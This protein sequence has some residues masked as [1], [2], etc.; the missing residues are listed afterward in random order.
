M[1]QLDLTSLPPP[2]AE[3]MFPDAGPDPVADEQRESLPV[4]AGGLIRTLSYLT[5]LACVVAVAGPL[6]RLLYSPVLTGIAIA[7]VVAVLTLLRAR[8]GRTPGGL[9]SGTVAVAN[10]SDHAPGLKRQLVRTTL[11]VLLHVTVVGPLVVSFFSRDGRD[12]VDRV[13]GTAVLDLRAEQSQPDSGNGDEKAEEPFPRKQENPGFPVPGAPT[14]PPPLAPTAPP[15]APTAPPLAPVSPPPLAP[16]SPPPLAPVPPPPI[17]NREKLETPQRPEKSLAPAASPLTPRRAASREPALAAPSGNTESNS[18]TP[19][20]AAP[21]PP[22]PPKPSPPSAGPS[23][24]P[25]AVQVWLVVDSGQR[26]RVDSVLVVGREPTGA[27]GERHVVIPDPTHSISRTHLRL[28]PAS[29]GVWVEDAASTNGTVVRNAAG[30]IAHLARGR[31]TLLP[32]GT[33]IIMGGRT[34]MIVGDSPQ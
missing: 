28:G 34:M 16:A 31:R 15:L 22:T 21:L 3:T 7:E 8:T 1:T 33:T 24:L 26:E 27:D 11:M 10:G 25:G 9:I 29:S 14:S 17:V 5:D 12:L 19:R 4:P 13:A 2:R 32:L 18:L 6:W 30:A 23:G 20:R